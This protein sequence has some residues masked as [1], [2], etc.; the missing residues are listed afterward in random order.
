MPVGLSSLFAQ[1]PP[2]L[3]VAD[4]LT[5]GQRTGLQYSRDRIADN[6]Y[7]R[8]PD[9]GITSFMGAISDAPGG[10]YFNHPTF[11][12]GRVIDPM[13]ARQRALNWE[14]ANGKQFARAASPM[15]SE[16]GEMLTHLVMDQDTERLMGGR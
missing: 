3:T 9:G 11:W 14:A 12:D 7:Q 13:A 16:L 2:P 6:T 4:L 1:P 15:S 10:G 8:N 5:E